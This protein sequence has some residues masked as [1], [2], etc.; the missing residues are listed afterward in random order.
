MQGMR[1]LAV[2]SVA[3]AILLG[4]AVWA[5]AGGPSGSEGER[6]ASPAALVSCNGT[7]QKAILVDTRDSPQSLNNEGVDTPVANMSVSRSVAANTSDTF[8]VTFSS[9]TEL[10]GAGTDDSIEVQVLANGAPLAPVGSVGYTGTG[11]RQTNSETFCR[12]LSGGPSG[13]TY[14]FTATWRLFDS[15]SN[16]TLAGVLDDTTMAVQVSE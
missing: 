3:F 1:K 13:T 9:Q 7:T 10:N 5:V 4:S 11:Q 16:S 15:G 14:T 2:S 12:R 8:V 6:G